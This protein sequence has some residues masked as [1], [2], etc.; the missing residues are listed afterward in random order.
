[1]S[2]CLVLPQLTGRIQGLPGPW[3][4]LRGAGF[5][6]GSAVALAWQVMAVPLCSAAG[7]CVKQTV[8]DH[9]IRGLYRGLSS[10]VYGSIPKAAV[11]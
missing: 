2:L 4:A 6:G 8:H 9:G 7:D 1:M 11:R 3:L 5:G 10:L